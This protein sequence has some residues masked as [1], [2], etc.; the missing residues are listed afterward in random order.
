MSERTGAPQGSHAP[1]VGRLRLLA[2]LRMLWAPAWIL[3]LVIWAQL[4]ISLVRLM[5]DEAWVGPAAGPLL[6]G[7]PSPL[8]VSLLWVVSLVSTVTLALGLFT[9]LSGATALAAG[10]LLGTAVLG[11]GKI[12]HSSQ[13][14]LLFL[15]VF[16]F[17]PWGAAWSL[18]AKRARRRGKPLPAVDDGAYKVTMLLMGLL[19]LASAFLKA[20]HGYF[21]ESGNLAGFARRQNIRLADWYGTPTPEWSRHLGDFVANHATFADWLAWGAILLEATILVGA[22]GARFRVL[23]S[24]MSMMLLGGIAVVA[25]LRFYG[26]AHFALLIGGATLV[27]LLRHRVAWLGRLFPAP[28]AWPPSA[29]DFDRPVRRFDWSTTGLIALVGVVLLVAA[30]VIRSEAWIPVDEWTEGGL[31]FAYGMAS[32]EVFLGFLLAGIAMSAWAA[33]DIAR[34]VALRLRRPRPDGTRRVLLYDADCGFCQTWVAWAQAREPEGVEFQ[35]CQFAEDL[36]PRVAIT[37]DR[38]VEA[39][40]LVT[41]DAAGQPIALHRG[42]GAINAAMGRF[43]K[44]P[45]FWWRG[46]AGAYQLDGVREAQDIGYAWVARNRHRLGDQSCPVPDHAPGR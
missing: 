14:I 22:L 40:Y 36:T 3:Q 25:P 46:L 21:L 35:A 29:D 15:V 31:V 20:W 9:R 4:N 6:F 24:G 34:R 45:G 16:V 23:A 11:W 19:Y 7:P 30:Q 42:A 27:L 38:C 5:P 8:F 32:S 1:D 13:P 43:Q 41:L 28:A 44:G 33:W 10:A 2:V 39:A 17:T 18:D 37:M 12:G 26:Q